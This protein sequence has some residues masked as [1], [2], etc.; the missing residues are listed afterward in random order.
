[1]LFAANGTRETKP[2]YSHLHVGAMIAYMSVTLTLILELENRYHRIEG[3]AISV[4]G[5]GGP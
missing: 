4:T 5:Q 1:M 3:K 2:Y